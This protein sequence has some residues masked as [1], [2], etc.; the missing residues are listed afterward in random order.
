[1]QPSLTA[2]GFKALNNSSGRS[3]F[4]RASLHVLLEDAVT[5]YHSLQA[6]LVPLRVGAGGG[7]RGVQGHGNDDTRM[8]VRFH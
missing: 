7:T 2:C 3:P 8:A 5:V 6:G 1:V 4:E